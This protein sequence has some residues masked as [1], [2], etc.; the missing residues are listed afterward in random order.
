MS[1]IEKGNKLEDQ[2]YAY[3]QDQL[4]RGDL[5]FGA[6][7]PEL[8][9]VHK[10][11][12]YLCKERGRD[13]EFDVV[14][15]IR[16]NNRAEPY[17]FVLF[18]CK[19]HKEPVKERDITDFS[20]KIGRIFGHRTKG[21][22]VTT[23]RLQS[24]AESIARSRGLGIVKFDANGVDV[25][26]ERTVGAWAEKRFVQRQMIDS[27][28]RSKSLKFS[29]C[30]DGRYF[31]SLL[32]ML[33]NFRQGWRDA[34]IEVN[35]HQANSV[36]FLPDAAIQAAAYDALTL[37]SYDGGEVHLE[38]LCAVLAL[39]LTYSER[40][41]QDAD[42]NTIL[43]SANFSKRSIEVNRHGDRNRER[44]TI[45]HEIG[46]FCLNHDKYL[47][48][49]SIIE[50]DLIFD[51]ETEDAFN[52][53]RLEYQ[54]N[55]FGSMMLL[56]EAQFRNAMEALRR[57]LNIYNKGF[58]HIFVDNQ[59]CN[60]VPYNQMLSALSEYFGASKQVIEIRLKRAGLVTDQ[61]KKSYPERQLP[62]VYQ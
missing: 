6:H 39:D 31:G 25:I 52:Y 49:E 48:S 9:E 1:T 7:P 10:K 41:L 61:R 22:I 56:P 16:R 2:L 43:G 34:E 46:H 19:N 26:A 8:C 20:D 12:K 30:N 27:P 14:V 60:Y 40:V 59:P 24:G 21:L 57:Q 36:P 54:A 53:D 11:K 35:D 13:V 45:A 55:L 62:G 18:E 33:Q 58:G 38:K 4:E 5:V 50:R 3:L 37:A 29:G 28:R 23:S 44:F 47:L 42:G 51:T 32:Q 15:E 17:S